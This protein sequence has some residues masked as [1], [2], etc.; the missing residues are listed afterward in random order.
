[1]AS[2]SSREEKDVGCNQKKLRVYIFSWNLDGDKGIIQILAVR[3]P[4]EGKDPN[5]GCSFE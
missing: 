3:N 4:G 5:K 2:S 1:V